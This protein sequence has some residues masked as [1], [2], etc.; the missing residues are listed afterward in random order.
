MADNTFRATRNRDPMVDPTARDVAS[1]PLAELARLIG[2]SDPVGEVGRN[3]RYSPAESPDSAAPAAA[4]LDWA[5]AE[6]NQY[7]EDDYAE[8]RRGAPEPSHPGRRAYAPADRDY[9]PEP[10]ISNQ[11]SA[12]AAHYD[13]A[14][15]SPGYVHDDPAVQ[16]WSDQDQPG[17]S[18]SSQ[19]PALAPE[20]GVE[21]YE[22]DDRWQGD[23]DA[24][25]PSYAMEDYDGAAGVGRQSGLVV[26]LAVLGLV[27]VGVA[28]AFAYRTVFGNSMLPSLP[29]II[30]ASDSPNKIIPAHRD[31]QAAASA[32][33][34]GGQTEKLVS[35]EEQPVAIQ[36]PPSNAPRVISTIPVLTPPGAGPAG[37]PVVAPPPPAPAAPAAAA[38]TPPPPVAVAPP[39][40]APAPPPQTATAEPK[41][42]HTVIIRSNQAAGANGQPSTAAGSARPPRSLASRSGPA[43]AGPN[44][45]LSIMPGARG[46]A[47]PQLREARAA[48][49]NEPLATGPSAG[50]SAGGYAVQITSQRTEAEAM[51]AFRSLRA[52]YPGALGEHA[53]II[54]RAELGAKGT[55]YR[56]FVGPYGSA[57]HA[58]EMCSKLK[59]AGGTCIVQRI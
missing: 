1:D 52:K 43:E 55:Y 22:T 23:G 27:T 50:A 28:G 19:L 2:Q 32:Q 3:A 44:A 35:R 39:P 21:G 47:P 7:A 46:E 37:T 29:P 36:P 51:A 16:D 30:K 49:A 18:I 53:P 5:A 41:K 57:E 59:A 10:P 54:R 40:P 15:P 56:A 58:A 17:S 20:S 6:P 4:G 24:D 26:V 45:P 14:D 12:R 38:P 13:E 34:G 9:E 33:P 42:V 11:Q 25:D 48:P 31:S 8:P